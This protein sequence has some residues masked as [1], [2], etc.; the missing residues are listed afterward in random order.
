MPFPV[1]T[2]PALT[3]PAPDFEEILRKANLFDSTRGAD[4]VAAKSFV[5]CQPK[6]LDRLIAIAVNSVLKGIAA[7]QLS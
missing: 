3:E 1:I 5:F 4:D 7:D 2:V 6:T